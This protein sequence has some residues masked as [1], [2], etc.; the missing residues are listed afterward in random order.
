MHHTD[1]D[2]LARI[3]WDY[4]HVGHPLRQADCILVLGSHDVRVGEWGVELFQRGMAPWIVFSG[5]LGRLTHGVFAKSEA[6]TFAEI[7]IVQGVPRDRILIE[8]QSTNTGE[9][10]DLTR[11]LLTERGLDFQTFLVVQKPYMERRA[12][13]TFKKRWP[14]KECICTSPPIPFEQYPNGEI[15]RD[16]IIHIMVGDLQRIREYPAR[17]Y[18]IPQ[19]IPATVWQ[20]YEELVRRGYTQHLIQ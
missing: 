16:T 6:D 10:L 20:A 4:H 14:D 19:E 2:H 11:R 13:T 18:Q 8:N 9:N 15:S 12:Y 7:A 3:V 5:G 1:V 17:G